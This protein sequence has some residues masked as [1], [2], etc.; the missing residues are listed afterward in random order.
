MSRVADP[1][2]KTLLI[3]AAEQVFGDRG[4]EGAKVEEIARAAG[5]SKGAF[6]L[7]FESKEAALKQIVESW[8]TRCKSLF[9]GPSEY[10]DAGEDPDSILDFSFEREVQLFEFFWETR[11]TIRILRSCQGE[12]AYLFDAFRAEMQARSRQW[13]EQ[14]RH[15]G[16]FRLDTNVPIASALMSGAYEELT[17]QLLGH[18]ARPPFEEWLEFAQMTFIRAFGAPELIAALE[19]RSRRATTGVLSRPSLP[20]RSAERDVRASSPEFT[21]DQILGAFAAQERE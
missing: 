14:W 6:Y 1:K 8:L 13:L 7:H 4:V 2:A 20:D 9:A 3:K 11:A 19:R 15:E 5:L 16:L 17:V 10:P 18:A 12:Y 21:T